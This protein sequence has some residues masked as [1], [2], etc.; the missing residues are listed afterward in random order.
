MLTGDLNVIDVQWIVQ[1]RIAD[2]ALTIIA[3]ALRVAD[4]V[5]GRLRA[6]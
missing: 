6:P 1:Y 5:R 3:Q 4:H 2:P